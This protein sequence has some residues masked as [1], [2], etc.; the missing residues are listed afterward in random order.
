MSAIVIPNAIVAGWS[1]GD[2][3]LKVPSAYRPAVGEIV[4]R[5]W[6]KHN[7]YAK[8]GLD[9]PFKPRTSRA[10]GKFHSLI[11]ILAP[12]I[13]MTF[14]ECKAFVKME[15]TELGYPVVQKIRFKGTRREHTI[16]EPQS[17]ADASTAQEHM[18]IVTA[19]KIGAEAGHDLEA[20]YETRMRGM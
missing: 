12:L 11:A 19:L 5:S 16:S 7:N 3:H 9:V 20:E 18:L 1:E 15:A 10:Q 2:L 13:D 4:A 8:V 6:K 17:E 14:D